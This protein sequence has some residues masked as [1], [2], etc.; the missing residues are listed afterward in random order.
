MEQGDGHHFIAFTCLFLT[1]QVTDRKQSISSMENSYIDL[2][3]GG[4]GETHSVEISVPLLF[5]LL[6]SFPPSFST[7]KIICLTGNV[8]SH[9]S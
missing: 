4:G 1:N 7:K 9:T 8:S 2:I 5:L 3:R 6:P